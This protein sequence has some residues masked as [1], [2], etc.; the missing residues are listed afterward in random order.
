MEGA[1]TAALGGQIGEIAA[2]RA[3]RAPIWTQSRK[4]RLAS[5][6]LRDNHDQAEL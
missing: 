6:T 5:V 4:S 3:Y 2:S 1:S